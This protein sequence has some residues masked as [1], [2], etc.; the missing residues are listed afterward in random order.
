MSEAEIMAE[1]EE[2][3]L[4]LQQKY[5]CTHVARSQIGIMRIGK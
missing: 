2:E 5:K 1:F 4:K 3:Y